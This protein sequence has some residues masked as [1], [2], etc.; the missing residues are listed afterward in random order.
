MYIAEFSSFCERVH[1]LVEYK[2]PDCDINFFPISLLNYLQ[3]EEMV[4]KR[5]VFFISHCKIFS[6][7]FNSLSAMNK[8]RE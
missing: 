7:A 3:K 6:V 4:E 5:R 1:N 8:D 2:K